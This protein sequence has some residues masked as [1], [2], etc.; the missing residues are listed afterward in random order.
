MS[1]VQ[2]DL[3]DEATRR[4]LVPGAKVICTTARDPK[5]DSTHGIVKPHSEWV[6]CNRPG[7]PWIS[8]GRDNSGAPL[9]I[10]YNRKWSAVI[11]AAPEAE[12]LKE[13]DAVECGPAMRAAIIELA[14]EL[15]LNTCA[16]SPENMRVIC[17]YSGRI[18]HVTE[19][20]FEYA[21]TSFVGTSPEAFMAK[22]RVTAALPKPEPPIK[23][24]G[25]E[26]K[27]GKGVIKVG[28]QTI[29]NETVRAIAAK[30]ID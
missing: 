13:G 21:G 23:I 2:Q 27:W 14:K 16:A 5:S 29:N 11:T 30:L 25:H 20:P 12:G 28:C 19:V 17:W 24:D 22:M 6:Y 8:A 18:D 4:G 26:V 10:H 15:G 9:Y 1:N 7:N 3:I